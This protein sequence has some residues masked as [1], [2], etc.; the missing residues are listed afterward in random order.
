MVAVGRLTRVQVQ[1]G[2]GAGASESL[3]VA[4]VIL[5]N[6]DEYSKWLVIMRDINIY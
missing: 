1:V 2:Q 6:I 4:Q 3:Q 5:R